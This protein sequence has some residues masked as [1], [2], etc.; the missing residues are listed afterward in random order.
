V[1]NHQTRYFR[2]LL[3]LHNF[4]YTFSARFFC[5]FLYFSTHRKVRLHSHT[6]HIFFRCSSHSHT[7]HFAI[8]QHFW[9]T[10]SHHTPHTFHFCFV[11]HTLRH[12]FSSFVSTHH[13]AFISCRIFPIQSFQVF[14]IQHTS[15]AFTLLFPISFSFIT[16]TFIRHFITNDKPGYLILS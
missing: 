12:L 2:T 11:P 16:H 15:F 8:I 13:I 7:H 10:H 5:Y 1:V 4:T 14:F 6:Q 9:S 3:T